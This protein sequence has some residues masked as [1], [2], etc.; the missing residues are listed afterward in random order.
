MTIFLNLLS[1]F[2]D[3]ISDPNS[4]KTATALSEK[5]FE[6]IQYQKHVTFSAKECERLLINR[7]LSSPE[8]C[9]SLPLNCD[10]IKS[11]HKNR[12]LGDLFKWQ[13]KLL[14]FVWR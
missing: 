12:Y 14:G 11:V 8:L 3:D 2:V 10:K 4:C 6:G 5:V 13:G 1:L 7:K 9:D